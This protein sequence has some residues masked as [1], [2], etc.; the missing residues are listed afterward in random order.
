MAERVVIGVGPDA[1]RAAAVLST[2]GH[3]VTLLQA[4][5]GP[6][7]LTHPELP[8]STGRMCTRDEVRPIAEQVLGPLVEAPGIG[9]GVQLAGRTWHLPL[10]R[11]DAPFFGPPAR[12][13]ALARGLLAARR[14]LGA[15]ELTGTG[16]EERSYK[17]W[18]VRR[19]GEPA[20][21]HLIAPWASRRHGVPAQRLGA[22]VARHHHAIP[23]SGPHQVPGGRSHVS[24]EAAARTILAAGGTIRDRVQVEGLDLRDGRVT[25]VRLLGGETIP[26]VGPLWVA[27]GPATVL[28][29]LPAEM[30][31]PYERDAEDLISADLL[32][33]CLKG[34]VDGLPEELHVLDD[35]APFWCVV[36]PY[37]IKEFA[38]FLSTT[39]PGHPTPSV[40]TMAREAAEAASRL[41]I[42]AFSAQEARLER[43]VEYQPVWTAGSHARFHRIVNLLGDNG[44]ALVG[45]TGAFSPLDPGA[46]VELALALCDQERPDVREAFRQ[47]SDPPARIDDLRIS[48]R[49]FIQR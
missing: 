9:K 15:A 14:E 39:L 7:G 27:R 42:G 12:R 45:R 35:D 8:H 40:E 18:V 41:G 5:P 31:A 46:E 26:V 25:G 28:S 22:A 11:R 43:M 32:V 21:T 29:W 13:W 2:A 16:K 24:L 23:D 36:S 37:G 1:L 47:I 33:L 20:W 44:I 30:R 4:G 49:P 34:E 48:L 38:L 10:R 6:S 19:M 17:D 3:A